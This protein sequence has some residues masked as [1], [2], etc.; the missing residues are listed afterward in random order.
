MTNREILDSLAYS[1]VDYSPKSSPGE[2]EAFLTGSIYRDFLEEMRVRIEDMKHVYEEVESKAF[3]ETKGGLRAM[4][5]V[6]GIFEDLYENA[7]VDRE[8][9]IPE[10]EN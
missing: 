6:A 8:R 1:K 7:K 5:M 9:P 4:R 2:L 3:L 10:E